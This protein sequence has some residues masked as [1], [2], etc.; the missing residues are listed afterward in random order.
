[1]GR[2]LFLLDTS[3][4]QINKCSPGTCE[5]TLQRC[6]ELLNIG[7]ITAGLLNGV[8]FSKSLPCNTAGEVRP[9]KN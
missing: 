2:N 8:A 1:M 6:I 9:A 7:N 4:L 3:L 5:C